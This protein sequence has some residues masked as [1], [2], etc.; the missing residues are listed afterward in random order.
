VHENSP[1]LLNDFSDAEC[2]GSESEENRNYDEKEC[3]GDWEKA[4]YTEKED[5][6]TS[7]NGGDEKIC[8]R[9]G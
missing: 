8:A 6:T 4:A 1:A 3:V 2:E 9:L 5:C 7:A